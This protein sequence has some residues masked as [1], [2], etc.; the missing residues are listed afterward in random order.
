MRSK[1]FF[2][3]CFLLLILAC[4]P[5]LGAAQ[6]EVRIVESNAFIKNAE[7]RVEML[8][9]NTGDEEKE[10]KINVNYLG[11][12]QTSVRTIP[13]NSTKLLSYKISNIKPGEIKIAAISDNNSFIKI[14]VPENLQEQQLLVFEIKDEEWQKDKPKEGFFDQLGYSFNHLLSSP[15]AIAVAT[16]LLIAVAVGLAVKITFRKKTS[17][18][19]EVEANE[20]LLEEAKN[21]ENKR[22]K[23]E[24]NLKL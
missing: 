5:L 2:A 3:A 14:V 16:V 1:I 15:D 7:L 20:K 24:K 8:F 22:K 12:L 13:A 11:Q 18:E 4:F 23:V 10:I 6:S 21:I 17:K 9:S 19:N